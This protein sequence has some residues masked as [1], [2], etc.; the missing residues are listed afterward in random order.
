M[1][2]VSE[3][4]GVTFRLA[5]HEDIDQIIK[6]LD[7]ANAGGIQPIL[8]Q[9]AQGNET[10]LDVARVKL[11]DPADELYFGN[12]LMA[13]VGDEVAGMMSIVI[14]PP[15]F[16]AIDI[17]A[18]EMETR[19]Y[20]RLRLQA[21]GM[22]FIRDTAVYPHFRERRLLTRMADL[23]I[24]NSWAHGYKGVCATVHESNV[25]LLAH[26]RKRGFEVVAREKLEKNPVYDPQSYML[27]LIVTR[28][29]GFLPETQAEL[30]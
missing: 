19:P 27:L 21:P 11:A 29:R 18:L 7:L 16:P 28:E 14:H 23:V 5:T 6:L 15:E 25:H 4:D 1:V 3:Q 10:W 12:V 8:S 17:D 20:A 26:M 13:F 24:R 2:P 30:G 9:V 22:P